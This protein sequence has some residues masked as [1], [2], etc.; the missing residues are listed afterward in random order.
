LA[1]DPGERRDVAEQHPERVAAMDA[2]IEAFLEETQAVTPQ[3]NPDYL[4]R[5]KRLPSEKK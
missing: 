1:E 2:R 3:L 5:E 4:P